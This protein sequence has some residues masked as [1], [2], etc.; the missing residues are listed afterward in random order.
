MQ[1]R[2]FRMADGRPVVSAQPRLAAPQPK[3]EKL[4][5]HVALAADACEPMSGEAQ[6][7]DGSAGLASASSM[8]RNNVQQ[9]HVA[10]N[11]HHD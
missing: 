11:Q 1:I 4:L 8:L 9:N 2:S 3:A 10:R 6:I 5:G 7:G